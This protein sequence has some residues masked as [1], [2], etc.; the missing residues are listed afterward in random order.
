MLVYTYYTTMQLGSMKSTLGTIN[1]VVTTVQ[2]LASLHTYRI[3][4]KQA[5]TR[6]CPTVDTKPN[7]HVVFSLQFSVPLRHC[8]QVLHNKA[9]EVCKSKAD[10]L[11]N[12]G[13]KGKRK[14][15]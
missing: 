14:Y 2:F 4:S 12:S 13:A 5:V 10:P 3:L 15:S 9:C 1:H 7:Q 11:R 8:N 6:T